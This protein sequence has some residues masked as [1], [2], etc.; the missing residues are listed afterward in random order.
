MKNDS[1][2]KVKGKVV[3]YSL[4]ECLLFYKNIIK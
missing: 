4:L 1:A 2:Y 3:K